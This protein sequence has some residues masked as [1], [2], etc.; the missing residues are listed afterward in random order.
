MDDFK[1][2]KKNHLRTALRKKTIDKHKKRPNN[3]RTGSSTRLCLSDVHQHLS[4]RVIDVDRSEDRSSVVRHADASVPATHGL[5][6]FVHA[7][8]IHQAMKDARAG[9]GSVQN[10]TFGLQTKRTWQR[11]ERCTSECRQWIPRS[12]S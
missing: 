12:W 5:Q 10:S 3:K 6:N 4:R 2:K 11:T 8:K 7:W 1:K 9:R